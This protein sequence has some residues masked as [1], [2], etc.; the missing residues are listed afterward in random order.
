MRSTLQNYLPLYQSRVLIVMLNSFQHL[1]VKEIPKQ[2]R[3]DAGE[4]DRMYTVLRSPLRLIYASSL[5]SST[6]E[7]MSYYNALI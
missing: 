1:I 5:T 7:Q 2:V 6:R 4:D 3:D